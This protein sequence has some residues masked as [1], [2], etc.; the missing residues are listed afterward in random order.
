MAQAPQPGYVCG[1]SS[2]ELER[3]TVQAS[4]YAPFTRSSLVR[5][6][7][8]PGMRVVDV[9]CGAGDVSLLAADLVGPGGAVL[10]L[11]RSPDAVAAAARRAIERRALHVRFEVADLENWSPDAPVD[12][13]I[14][15]FVL[16]HQQNPA[17]LLAHLRRVLPRGC[18]V[19]FIESDISAC[20]P[21]THSRPHSP[22]YHLIVEW[23]KAIIAAAGA[24]L[25]MG[26]QLAAAFTGAGFMPPTVE[27]GSYESGGPDSPMVRFAI[28]SL[29]SMLP[30]ATQAGLAAP[31]EADLNRLE[32]QL[33][34]ELTE[35][36]RVLA[37]PPVVAA[38]AR[39]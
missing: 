36:G 6:G 23:W 17:A 11:D 33:R 39:V 8:G 5:A 10:G 26:S 13:V 7:I 12:A 34:D 25:D 18:L 16:M 3:L 1:H 37:V 31:S 15:R 28:D 2:G 24:H 20:R 29:R 4:L 27:A 22:A 19:A 9:G 21:G 30:L 38:W 35:S 14:G 32:A